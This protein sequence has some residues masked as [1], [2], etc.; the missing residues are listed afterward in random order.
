MWHLLGL[1]SC[2]ANRT[3]LDILPLHT[4][5]HLVVVVVVWSGLVWSDPSCAVVKWTNFPE[6]PTPRSLPACVYFHSTA[7]RAPANASRR[8]NRYTAAAFS[9]MSQ[10]QTTLREH[11]SYLIHR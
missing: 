7:T 10:P 9:R 8:D 3:P 4:G 6:L 5:S 2:Q 11:S 1:V